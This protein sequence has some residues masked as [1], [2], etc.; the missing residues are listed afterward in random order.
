MYDYIENLSAE[1]LKYKGTLIQKEAKLRKIRESEE[2]KVMMNQSIRAIFN[3]FKEKIL[4]NE[5]F[6]ASHIESLLV[7]FFVILFRNRS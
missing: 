6:N 4:Y 2:N 7:I 3:D 5:I 1:I